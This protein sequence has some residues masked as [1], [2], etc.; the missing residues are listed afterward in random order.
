VIMD[1]TVLITGAE[2]FV[3]H[4]LAAFLVKEGYKVYGTT[5]QSSGPSNPVLGVTY[6]NVDICDEK[7]LNEVFISVMPNV[8][9]HL[10]AIS[11]VG[12]SWK[13]PQDTIRV[14]AIGTANL[15]AVIKEVSPKTKLLL[16]G[17]SEEYGKND[18]SHLVSESAP[19]NPQN[20]YALTKAFQEQLGRIYS[21]AYGL[22]IYMTRSFNHFGPGQG[23]GFVVSDFCSQIVSIERGLQ[24]PIIRV[25]NLSAERDFT[26]VEDVVR[27]YL[28]VIQKGVPGLVYNVG[29]GVPVC[30]ND[31]LNHLLSFSKI[32][33]DVVVDKARI[34]PI[35][36]PTIC[37]DISRLSKLGFTRRWQLD[38]ALLETLNDY[39]CLPIQ[40]K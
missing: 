6:I 33:I 36:T 29:S 39:R 10:A 14:N 7:Q 26:F 2:G 23:K 28:L 38:E 30:I 31:L 3:G 27:A 17:S 24:D 34:R 9:F 35:E 21:S 40:A 16:V 15:L 12:F 22:P 1:Q 19:L 11:S 5:L 8:V 4:H 20:V 13:N 37:A 18:Y 32:H 25:G